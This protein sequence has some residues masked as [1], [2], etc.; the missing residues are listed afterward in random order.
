MFELSPD[1]R[2]RWPLLVGAGGSAGSAMLVL[3]DKVARFSNGDEILS[4][5]RPCSCGRGN[6]SFRLSR[7]EIVQ[8]LARDQLK[9][10][11]IMCDQMPNVTDEEKAL[12]KQRL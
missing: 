7:H 4:Y 6:A 5:G 2:A 12:I 1:F 8:L 9:V 10:Y 3:T 11:C